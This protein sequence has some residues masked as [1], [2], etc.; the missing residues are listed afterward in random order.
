MVLAHDS[1]FGL[2]GVNQGAG[3]RDQGP[4]ARGQ[5]SGVRCQRSGARGQGSVICYEGLAMEL[6]VDAG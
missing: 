3:V 5:M 6:R 1:H 2:P 4:G